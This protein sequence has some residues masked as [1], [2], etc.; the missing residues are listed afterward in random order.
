MPHVQ[1]TQFTPPNSTN[2]PSLSIESQATPIQHA[3]NSIGEKWQT[4]LPN[5][6]L[7]E[8]AYSSTSSLPHQYTRL[9]LEEQFTLKRWGQDIE[10][11]YEPQENVHFLNA[12]IDKTGS[13]SFYVRAKGDRLTHGSGRDMFIGLMNKL[14]KEGIEIKQIKTHWETK[15][16][17][18]NAQEFLKNLNQG[19]SQQEAASKTWT[20]RLIAHYRFKPE[21][22]TKNGSCHY[23][24][25]KKAT[26]PYNNDSR[27]S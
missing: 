23:V 22:F 16:E 13:L 9:N 26:P 1:S 14:K 19:M 5:T 15:S 10:V 2:A 25:F 18:V 12:M 20:G 3:V 17:S 11:N 21:T 8:N 24:V 6:Y 4:S 27:R 7:E